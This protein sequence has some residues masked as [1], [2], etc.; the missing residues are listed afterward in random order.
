[1]VL[2]TGY[3]LPVTGASAAQTASLSF[4][5]STGSYYVGSTFDVTAVLDTHE[6]TI[7]TVELNIT[8]PPDLLQVVKP[9]GGSSFIQSWFSPPAFSNAEGTLRLIGGI[10][11]G[12]KTSSGLIT[13]LTFR[14]VAPGDATL[15]ILR[16]SKVLAHD[17][18]GTD[19]LGTR[20][21]ALFAIRVRPP[22][23]PEISSPTN[24]DP[25]RWYQNNAPRFT[26][27]VIEGAAGYSY[28]LSENV[29][30]LPPAQIRVMDTTASFTDLKDGV[31]YFH[32]RVS[33]EGAWSGASHFPVWIDTVPPAPFT[34]RAEYAPQLGTP[35]LVFFEAKDLHSGTDHY[36]VKVIR[37]DEASGS[38]EDITPFFVETESPYKVPVE[39]PGKYTVIV[40][41]FDKAGNIRD[42][43]VS[44]VTPT[45]A[46]LSDQGIRFKN[47][48]IPFKVLYGSGALVVIVLFLWGMYILRNIRA[49]RVRV[50]HD[51]ASLSEEMQKEYMR[52]GEHFTHEFDERLRNRQPLPPQAPP[53]ASDAD[54]PLPPNPNR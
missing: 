13:T 38:E 9:A 17:G 46:L 54:M 30:D 7:N 26:W 10:A 6:E 35:P 41:A 24:P 19:V 32:L 5:P 14:A 33:Q 36:A 12:I 25:N 16:T 20:G 1:M 44:L 4:S 43:T 31:W 15:A 37:V 27:Q 21:S 2:V 28:T 53:S 49:M 40:R 45:V 42:A 18:Q 52:F 34:P 3:W 22:E 39:F 50:K 48:F 47:Y 23:G 51:I 11:G 29:E 8:F